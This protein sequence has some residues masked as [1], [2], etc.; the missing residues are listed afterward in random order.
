[1]TWHWRPLVLSFAADYIFP[2]GRVCA[3]FARVPNG[4]SLRAHGC[5]AGGGVARENA[6]SLFPARPELTNVDGRKRPP[7]RAHKL[8]LPV[9][10]EALRAPTALFDNR[11]GVSLRRQNRAAEGGRG[12]E[13]FAGRRAQKRNCLRLQELPFFRLATNRQKLRQSVRTCD[14]LRQTASF[15]DKLRET[16][17][18]GASGCGGSVRGLGGFSPLRASRVRFEV[19]LACAGGR[20]GRRCPYDR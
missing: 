15:C 10:M 20:C 19:G 4:T 12:G 1:M 5:T 16:A 6:D 11:I 17:T 7:L 13:I 2:T 9:S 18:F 3:R 8:A 14:R